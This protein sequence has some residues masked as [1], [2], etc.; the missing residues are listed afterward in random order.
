MVENGPPQGI[1][2][3]TA[4]DELVPG[5]SQTISRM[6]F[7]LALL[8]LAVGLTWAYFTPVDM[9]IRAG[10]ALEAEGGIVTLT[11]PKSGMVKEVYVSVGDTVKREEPLIEL[12]PEVD[13]SELDQAR[14]EIALLEMQIKRY[15]EN[16]E[17]ALEEWKTELSRLTRT[18]EENKRKAK[19]FRD[20]VQAIEQKIEKMNEAKEIQLRE[21]ET[22]RKLAETGEITPIELNKK[23]LQLNNTEISIIDLKRQQK[24]RENL[25]EESERLAKEL[26]EYE[27][28]H[29]EHQAED[30]AKQAEQK[31]EEETARKGILQKKLQLLEKLRRKLTLRSTV[32]GKV[33]AVAVEHPGTILGP[34]QP[35]VQ[36]LPE[37]VPLVAVIHIESG[38]I[39]QAKVGM[40]V[41]LRLNGYPYQEYGEI[42]G[43]LSQI[44][45]QLDEHGHFKGTVTYEVKD[46]PEKLKNEFLR[47]GLPLISELVGEQKKM[48]DFVFEPFQKLKDPIRVNE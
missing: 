19:N 6:I 45:P 34:T 16:A 20:D 3:R 40:K 39:R 29:K 15:Q 8:L 35:A 11:V 2:G 1:F 4:E 24:D 9:V 5:R 21:L 27:I 26:Q 10:G 44:D 42:T 17:H 37:N 43:S 22:Y 36:I 31:A 12:D 23:E 13:E 14:E 47:P 48:I 41:L 46:I 33:V 32:N 25:A 38:Q 7:Y 28:P 18:I 30:Q